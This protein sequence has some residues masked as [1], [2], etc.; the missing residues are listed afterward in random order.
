MTFNISRSSTIVLLRI[1]SFVTTNCA[2][3]IF[4]TINLK[5]LTN[6]TIIFKNFVY[7]ILNYAVNLLNNFTHPI[8]IR[9]VTILQN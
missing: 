5:K 4:I 9:F 6:E 2:F 1:Y 8:Q 7:S 3:T